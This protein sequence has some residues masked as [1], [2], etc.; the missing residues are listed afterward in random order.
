M[1]TSVLEGAAALFTHLKSTRPCEWR[2]K[3]T[4]DW[5][6]LPR[7]NICWTDEI[8]KCLW[9]IMPQFIPSYILSLLSHKLLNS[10][11]NNVTGCIKGML[12]LSHRHVLVFDYNVNVKWY[13]M[14]STL[15]RTSWP[16]R[17]SVLLL[18]PNT[19]C[20]CCHQYH[21]W[22]WHGAPFTNMV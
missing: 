2:T 16:V 14:Y 4:V 22:W 6:L 12:L 7:I 19:S 20:L 21:S 9:T 18:L 1:Q 8:S 10:V 17:T 5:H 15:Y 11:L 3:Q 13:Q